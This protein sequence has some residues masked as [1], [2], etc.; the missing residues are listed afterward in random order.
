MEDVYDLFNVGTKHQFQIL[1][2]HEMISHNCSYLG[3]AATLKKNLESSGFIASLEEC[4]ALIQAYW[5]VIP[6]VTEYY[7]KLKAEWKANRGWFLSPRSRPMS[8]PPDKEKDLE[9]LYTTCKLPDKPQLEPLKQLLV[10]CL[11]HHYGSLDDCI[12][13]EQWAEQA[14]KEI[15]ATLEGVRKRLYR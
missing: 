5:D 14:L 6:G 3:G 2:N 1:G 4:K 12:T 13:Q 10:N 7:G 9:R 15:D 11:E 8:V